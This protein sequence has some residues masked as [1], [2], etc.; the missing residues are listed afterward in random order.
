LAIKLA[1]KR[2][3]MP[4]KISKATPELLPYDSVIARHGKVRIIINDG[5]AKPVNDLDSC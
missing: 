5:I 4:K 1:A 3:A 2:K